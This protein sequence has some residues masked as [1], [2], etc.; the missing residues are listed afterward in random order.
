LLAVITS[1]LVS[2]SG[3]DDDRLLAGAARA[4]AE[5]VAAARRRAAAR[6][7]AARP[8]RRRAAAAPVVALDDLL[9]DVG[10]VGRLRVAQPHHVGVAAR[11]DLDVEEVDPLDDLLHRL[12]PGRDEER[13]GVR[14]GDDRRIGLDARRRLVAGAPAAAL[15]AAAAARAAD[16]HVGLDQLLQHRL[17]LVR[18]GVVE[19]ALGDARVEVVGL[20]VDLAEQAHDALQVV[21][22]AGHQDGVGA[23]D[24]ADALGRA[25]GEVEL[26]RRHGLARG[27]VLR[28]DRRRREQAGVVGE[29]RELGRQDDLRLRLQRLLPARLLPSLRS[30]R[31]PASSGPNCTIRKSRL[32]STA[33]K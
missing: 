4:A 5:P 17:D 11:V 10:E 26:Q 24:V 15:A 2:E 18:D 29:L 22:E 27:Q 6:A 28:R 9:Q 1:E 7:A 20:L 3:D 13:V 31:K 33:P 8:A 25:V 32:R 30:A 14:V 16:P 23:L 12:R 19:L 21:G